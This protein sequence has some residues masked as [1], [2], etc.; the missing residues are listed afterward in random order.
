MPNFRSFYQ[1]IYRQLKCYVLPLFGREEKT[2][3]LPQLFQD[4]VPSKFISNEKHK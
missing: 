3:T 4:A 2:A 1:D